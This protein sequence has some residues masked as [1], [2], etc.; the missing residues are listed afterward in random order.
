MYKPLELNF[1]PDE[2]LVYLRKSRSDDPNLTVAEVLSRHESMLDDWAEKNLGARVPDQNKYREVV[3]G[4]TIDDR[5]EIC[6]LLTKVESPQYKAVLVVEVQRL[7][8]GDLEDAGR[9][10]KLLRYTNTIVITPMKAYDLSDEYDR[11]FFERELK[12][13]NE[14]L[15]YLKKIMG[16]GRLLSLQQGN[17]VGNT[18]PYGYDKATVLDGKKKCPTLTINEEQA[19]VVRM[20]FELYVHQ[21][22]GT[23]NIAH[24]LNEL[25]IH[26]LHGKY[27]T[28]NSIRSM[29]RNVHYTGKVRWN[30]RK[31]V[32]VV[33]NGEVVKKRPQAAAEDLLI[34]EGKHEAIISQELFQAAAERYGTCPRVQSTKELRN[35]LSGLLYC[36]CGKAMTLRIYKDKN[37][38]ER[39]APRLL[40]G[41]Q[42][43]CHVPSCTYDEMVERVEEVLRQ[44]ILDFELEIKRSDDELRQMNLI[45]IKRLDQKISELRK[46][47]LRQWEKYSEEGMP[48]EIFEQLNEKVLADIRR[49]EEAIET[50]K[51][52]LPSVEEYEER[53]VR[54]RDALS[55]LE[56]P[57]ESPAQKNRLL[58]TCI[59]RIDYYR[60]KGEL[61]TRS[62]A[63]AG[64]KLHVGANWEMSPIHIDVKLKL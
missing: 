8:R 42:S 61:L 55:A 34:Y 22:M 26:P 1:A 32:T 6:R 44:S 48:K 37:G 24:R 7:S 14:F 58:K 45:Q 13:G 9:L 49:T 21:N 11:D 4:E 47:E 56:N 53:L 46:K 38:R 59:E 29:L 35:P 33:E 12:R 10:M 28:Q 40:C 18:P 36:S 63:G 64:Q 19:Q 41:G 62:T 50:A 57:N 17:F 27:W 39:S 52:L 51:K 2:V 15:E 3:S 20:V 16:R 5:P 43:F 23:T 25:N 60:E 31:T 30:G 54:F